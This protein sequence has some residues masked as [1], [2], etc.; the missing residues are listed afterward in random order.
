LLTRPTFLFVNEAAM[1]RKGTPPDHC[2]MRM[3]DRRA[4]SG[5]LRSVALAA[6][7][8]FPRVERV[9][10]PGGRLSRILFDGLGIEDRVSRQVV[11]C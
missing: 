11:A 4:G 8:Y 5:V 9:A 2:A 3:G 7:L 6:R 10:E 1:L